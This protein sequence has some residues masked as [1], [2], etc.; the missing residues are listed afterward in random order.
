MTD[1]NDD[2]ISVQ[3]RIDPD[4]S[5][6]G[7]N[8]AENYTAFVNGYKV[9]AL[10]SQQDGA[11]AVYDGNS[12]S[13]TVTD[14][15]LVV[16]GDQFGPNFAD[17]IT[18]DLNAEGGVVVTE[19][20]ETFSFTPRRDPDGLHLRRRRR[21]HDQRPEDVLLLPGVDHR[22]RER[23]GEH[24][25]NGSVQGISGGDDHRTRRASPRSTSTTRPTPPPHTAIARHRRPRRPPDRG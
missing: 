17:N 10:W 1:P 23:H 12:Q 20:G 13:V 5:E 7:D 21:Q 19:N 2:G 18:V 16:T 25:R 3:P 8:E 11:Y 15:N 22:R 24:R 4:Q 9:Q 14:A 6:I